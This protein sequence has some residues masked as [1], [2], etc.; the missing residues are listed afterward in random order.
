V[1]GSTAAT[2]SWLI[3]KLTN[4]SGSLPGLPH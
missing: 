4:V 3:L 1:P 2:P